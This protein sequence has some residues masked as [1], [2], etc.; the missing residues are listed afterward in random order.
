MTDSAAEW[1]QQGIFDVEICRK[2]LPGQP[3]SLRF[4]ESVD[5]TNAWAGREY[6]EGSAEDG[7]V[8]L[9]DHQTA[10]RGRRGRAW[11]SPEHTSVSMSLLLNP[12][13]EA[14]SVSM[15]TLV[16]GMA[17]AEGIRRQSG[18]QAGIK[19]P[20]DIV[21]GGKK[22]C[23]IL[24]EYISGPEGRGA[25]V[26]GTG[27]NVNI[28]CFPEELSDK[29]TSL[30]L[31][32]GSMVSRESVTAGVLSAFAA[33]YRTFLQTGD[34]SGLI[35][36]YSELLVTRDR[37]V[38]VLDPA[39]AFEGTAL[40]INARGELLVRRADTG[41]VEQV[42]AGEVSVRGMLGYV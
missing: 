3:F 12:D 14:S 23:G 26:I 25:V 27:I 19:W 42:Y 38:R 2:L 22:I 29:A 1:E 37:E 36:Q 7:T 32:T 34:M 39:G 18:V 17:A 31:E 20:N 11:Q 8:F 30:Y 16:M 21:C 9:A 40:G 6:R 28:P 15:L 41:T 10:G 33:Y 24:T 35:G 4:S 13:I 5:S